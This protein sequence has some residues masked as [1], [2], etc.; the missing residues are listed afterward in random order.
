VDKKT[1]AMQNDVTAKLEYRQSIKDKAT[2]HRQGMKVH[3]KVK[4]FTPKVL[5]RPQKVIL[6]AKGPTKL[7]HSTWQRAGK[8]EVKPLL[9]TSKCKMTLLYVGMNSP[10]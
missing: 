6:S 8:A 9:R 5:D 4:N 10:M 1:E 3:E 2:K 7:L